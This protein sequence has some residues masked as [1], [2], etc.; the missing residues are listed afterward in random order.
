MRNLFY[1]FSFLILSL[2]C[3]EKNQSFKESTPELYDAIPEGVISEMVTEEAELSTD[4]NISNQN[5]NFEQKLIKSS[6]LTFETKSVETTFQEVKQKVAVYGGYIQNDQTSKEYDR[7]NRSLLI[8]IPNKNFQILVDSITSSVKSLD[9]RDIDIRDVTEEYVDIKAR[10]KAK[11][12]LEERYLQLLSKAH[13]VKDMLEIERQIAQIREEIEA[14]QGR[15][16]YL[17]NKVSLSSIHLNFYEMIPATKA[18]SQTYASR[19]WR[20]VKGGFEGIGEFI[21]G[22]VYIWPFLLLGLLLGFFIRHRIKKSKTQK[23]SNKH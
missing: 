3:S 4:T 5:A 11:Q 21:I 17:E 16:N 12:K 20:A 9:K 6:Y 23:V 2:S 8:R 13:S 14:K 7:I 1:L 10:L 15:L 22:I 18:P 19:L